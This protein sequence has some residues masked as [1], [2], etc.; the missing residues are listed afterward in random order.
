MQ[1]QKQVWAQRARLEAGEVQ[2]CEHP[3][4]ATLVVRGA[5]VVLLLL[6]LPL[7]SPSP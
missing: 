3:P 4:A 2:L 7:R 5:Q 1:G 6:P